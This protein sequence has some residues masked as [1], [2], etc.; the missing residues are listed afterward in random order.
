MRS[1]LRTLHVDEQRFTWK[2]EIQRGDRRIRVRVWGAGK[3]G[4][5]LQADLLSRDPETYAYPTADDVRALIRY[6]L[7]NGWQPGSIGGTF[8]IPASAAV[9]LPAL[10]VTDQASG[11]R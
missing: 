6:A 1:R 2:A 5:A 4:R 11:R 8:P 9:H 3:T 10:T 7:A